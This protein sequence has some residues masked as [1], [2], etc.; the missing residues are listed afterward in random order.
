M[1][2]LEMMPEELT[3]VATD[4]ISKWTTY[5]LSRASELT[6]SG[7]QQAPIVTVTWVRRLHKA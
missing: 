4:L 6:S 2:S 1:S 3:K 5:L 7:G